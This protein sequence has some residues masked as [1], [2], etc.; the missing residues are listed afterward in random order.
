MNPEKIESQRREVINILAVE[1]EEDVRDLY[2][3]VLSEEGYRVVT[4]SLGAEAIDKAKKER[5]DLVILDLR[6]PDMVGPELINN[7]SD[8]IEGA[9]LIIVTAFPSLETSLGAIKAGV[10][11]YMVKPVSPN[12]LKLVI[13]RAVTKIQLVK[14]K[15]RLLSKLEERNKRLEE[16]V[17]EIENIANAAMIREK[18]LQKKVEELQAEIERLKGLKK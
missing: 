6:L 9:T 5:F 7:I 8:K 12:Q 10:Y 1:D 18:E 17:D 13:K 16:N 11:D 14:E 15:E 2:T 3:T 4:A